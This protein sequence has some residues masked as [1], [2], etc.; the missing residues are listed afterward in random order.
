MSTRKAIAV[1]ILGAGPTGAL[2]S[3]ALA[4]AGCDVFLYDKESENSII[5]RN[6]SYAITHSSRRL[7]QKLGIW[8]EFIL[9]SNSF[10]KLAISDMY[11]HYTAFFSTND[12]SKLN[13]KPHQLLLS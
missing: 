9:T 8:H 6:K 3:L 11:S 12:L 10:E 7:L 13:S 2:L 1:N 5:I 4:E